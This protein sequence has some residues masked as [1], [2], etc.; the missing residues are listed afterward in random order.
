[1]QTLLCIPITLNVGR[2]NSSKQFELVPDQMLSSEYADKYNDLLDN[3]SYRI[4]AQNLQFGGGFFGD[5][6][7]GIKSVASTVAPIAESVIPLVDH[8]AGAR[9]RKVYRRAL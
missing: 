1:L 8:L 7:N 2:I 4:T 6:W 9:P 5:L 3:A